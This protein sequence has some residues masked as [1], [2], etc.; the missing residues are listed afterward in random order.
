MA[1]A[2]QSFAAKRVA[3]TLVRKPG[4]GTNTRRD[5]DDRVER[6]TLRPAGPSGGDPAIPGR[7]DSNRRRLDHERLS[8]PRT[9]LKRHGKPVMERSMAKALVIHG[10]PILTMD[11]E[12]PEVEA[13]AIDHGMV[14]AT[15]AEAVVRDRVGPD[16]TR[17]DPIAH[18]RLGACCDDHAV[19]DSH[20]FD[21]WI[22]GIHGE[23][24][25]AV[26]NKRFRH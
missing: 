25:T 2:E 17:A 7:G 16:A 21:L 15:G 13:V 6:W 5:D 22:L 4:I 9:C 20:R 3:G 14:I 26:N 18:H 24:R 23:D 1:D 11:P 12:N 19:I 10:G 8:R